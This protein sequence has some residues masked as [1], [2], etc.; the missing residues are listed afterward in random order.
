MVSFELEKQKFIKPGQM[1]V[2]LDRI[3]SLE[4]FFLTGSFQW[5]AIEKNLKATNEYERQNNEE[6]LK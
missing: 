3:K 2:T 1:N 4:R 6:L 5:D